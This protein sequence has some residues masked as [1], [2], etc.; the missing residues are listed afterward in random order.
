MDTE[1]RKSNDAR[2][3][4]WS[5]EG[6]HRLIQISTPTKRS[7]AMAN[8]WHEYFLWRPIA[9]KVHPVPLIG[10]YTASRAM[11]WSNYAFYDVFFKSLFSPYS[12]WGKN[13]DGY[14]DAKM[15]EEVVGYTIMYERTV[16]SPYLKELGTIQ[17]ECEELVW[18]LYRQSEN[19]S[20]ANAK[21]SALLPFGK[22]EARQKKEEAERK[23]PQ[24]RE[25]IDQLLA[26][27][28]KLRAIILR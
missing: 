28:N 11:M 17:D 1:K 26:R 12:D 25:Q 4:W 3:D 7:I 10:T 14:S 19:L 6:D 20:E 2:Y 9:E 23:I 27:V 8:Q 22:A 24:L 16:D 13:I 5:A 21:L 18:L 15:Y